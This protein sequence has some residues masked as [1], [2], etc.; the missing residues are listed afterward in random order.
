M[1]YIKDIK[2]LEFDT[3]NSTQIYALENES[4]LDNLTFIRCN[5][6]TLGHG[7]MN[8]SWLSNG[9]NLLF[10]F[11]I[12]DEYLI[13]HF[14]SLSLLVGVSIFES[15]SEFQIKSL[16]KWPNDIYV[17][18]KKIC[19][20]ILEASSY[21]NIDS[22]SVGVGLNVNMMDFLNLN[23][24]SMKDVTGI[25]YD[26]DTVKKVVYQNIINSINKFI[27][28]PNYY[29][30]IINKNNYLYNKRVYIYPNT[31]RIEGRVLRINSNNSIEVEASGTIQN[32][33]SDEIQ[34][35]N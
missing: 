34:L 21:E 29:I 4:R 17:N 6:Q 22:I 2:E 8:R 27:D 13:E 7:R 32:V 15:L 28:E 33:S 20:I 35:L 30:D 5:N 23:A 10:S 11:V 25:D 18:D 24:T 12:K 9:S 19:G 14:E 26:I 1:Y 3:I 31:K 16:I